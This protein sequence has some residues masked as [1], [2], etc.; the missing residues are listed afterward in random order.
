MHHSGTL[1][2]ISAPSGAGKTSLVKALVE[3]DSQLFVSVSHTT[4][5][6]RSGEENGVNYYFVSRESFEEAVRNETFFE[7]AEVFGNLYGTAIEP[8]ERQ[9][10]A[11]HDVIL[12]IDW[13]GAAQVK[14]RVPESIHIFILPPSLKVLRER[15]VGRGQDS[16]EVIEGRMAQAQN[17]L[18][19]WSEADYLVVNDRFEHALDDLKHIVASQRL[20]R[21]SQSHKLASQLAKLTQN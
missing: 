1:Y 21:R 4:R 12:E 8:V 19:H 11:G 17:E 3:Q 18:V 5:R 6:Q 20:S 2:T 16:D 10:Q 15:L 7:W 9:L 13:Q 14:K